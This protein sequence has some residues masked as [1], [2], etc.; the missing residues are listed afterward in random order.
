MLVLYKPG[1]GNDVPLYSTHTRHP[2]RMHGMRIR[3]LVEG[4][5]VKARHRRGRLKLFDLLLDVIVQVVAVKDLWMGGGK[6]GQRRQQ[7]S[8]HLVAPRATMR[9]S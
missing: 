7:R 2:T 5:R 1:L 3:S 6:G 4:D 8:G 9:Q